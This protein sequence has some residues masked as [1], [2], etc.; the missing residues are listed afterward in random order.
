M[1]EA[2]DAG[3]LQIHGTAPNTK[4]EGT[5][6]L[7][8]ENP[9]GLNNRIGGNEKLSKAL[10]IKDDLDADAILY[11]EHR[12]NLRHKDNRNDFK[13]MFQRQLAC[14][15]VEAH[16]VHKNVSRAQ[17]GGTAAIAFDET[18]GYAKQ[19]WRDP[20][21]LGRWAWIRYVGNDGHVTRVAV[22]YNPC[23]NYKLES[24]TV[25]QQHRRYFVM[26][27]KDLTFPNKLFRLHL[28]SQLKK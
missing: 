10:E 26:K 3:L 7:I 28:I 12:F 11:A 27:K 20:T 9:N 16:N 25:Y 13:Q 2:I 23:K 17:E 8:C 6:R 22:A 24:N 19:T 15:A 5:F 18:S 1:I 14:K 4:Q 21:G